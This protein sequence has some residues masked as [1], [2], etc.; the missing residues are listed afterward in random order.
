MIVYGYMVASI[1]RRVSFRARAASAMV[2]CACLWAGLGGPGAFVVARSISQTNTR[3]RDILVPVTR[4]LVPVET[5]TFVF[6]DGS[7]CRPRPRPLY[8]LD[9]VLM[10]YPAR[11]SAVFV[12][13]EYPSMVLT[14]NPWSS[15]QSFR[16]PDPASVLACR[17]LA[18]AGQELVYAGTGMF[19]HDDTVFNPGAFPAS[20]AASG[21]AQLGLAVPGGAWGGPW[22]WSNATMYF[23][24]Q[25]SRGWVQFN[26]SDAH[27]YAALPPSG[28]M[29]SE[30]EEESLVRVPVNTACLMEIERAS[31]RVGSEVV[32]G[33]VVE[34][35][36][37]HRT[38]ELPPAL[39]DV[40]VDGVLNVHDAE[41]LKA[42]TDDFMSVTMPVGHNGEDR[43]FPVPADALLVDRLNDSGE[44]ELQFLA[45]RR[46]THPSRVRLGC[47][48]LG[49]S[50]FVDADSWEA[51]GPGEPV[52]RLGHVN[53]SLAPTP[54]LQT[55]Y[56]FNSEVAFPLLGLAFLV[57]VITTDIATTVQG[58]VT[59]VT[60]ARMSLVTSMVWWNEVL[61]VGAGLFGAATVKVNLYYLHLQERFAHF[62]GFSRTGAAPW[63]T[64]FVWWIVLLCALANTW[65]CTV[66]AVSR[67]KIMRQLLKPTGVTS[68][69]T[70]PELHRG[71]VVSMAFFRG[72]ENSV[73]MGSL[74]VMAYHRMLRSALFQ[75][76]VLVP[77]LVVCLEGD[78]AAA[79]M[80]TFVL[81]TVSCML[82]VLQGV[83]AVLLLA[84]LLH[85]LC[86]EG[87]WRFQKRSACAVVGNWLQI[88][89]LG[90]I[91][92]TLVAFA[93]GFLLKPMIST[94]FASFSDEEDWVASIIFIA[95][96]LLAAIYTVRS[97]ASTRRR[98][99]AK[100]KTGV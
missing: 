55:S 13:A 18:V 99:N 72:E 10:G 84:T 43:V 73:V 15:S 7:V 76:S 48:A 14:S 40:V 35:V 70:D 6:Q 74:V 2:L 52:G 4:I 32:H 97:A 34:L 51:A 16:V 85:S 53:I 47:A 17:S 81:L 64:F 93:G 86:D 24:T 100:Y 12:D 27:P 9:G 71:G 90:A 8:V 69:A 50:L 82:V 5:D 68:R 65:L 63:F 87:S 20:V 61:E 57:W 29:L 3:Q 11:P 1:M 39:Y 31:V 88:A 33:V 78:M 36:A 46:G 59:G 91:C 66:E 92:T 38:I 89:L 26:T 41:T 21:L 23:G 75:G 42:L 45:L 77:L 94:R 37:T 54:P 96:A 79:N 80:N 60:R 67:K 83:N 44:L 58:T 30:V 22:G 62:T 25:R 95:I 56:W 28:N 49:A 19:W 98:G